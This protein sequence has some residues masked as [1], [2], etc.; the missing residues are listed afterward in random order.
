MI[1]HTMRPKYDFL[2]AEFGLPVGATSSTMVLSPVVAV[3]S[4]KTAV[5]VASGG[6]TTVHTLPVPSTPHARLT[7]NPSLNSKWSGPAT[8]VAGAFISRQFD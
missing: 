3:G 6:G 8:T 4:V 5:D 2:P 7:S 1:L